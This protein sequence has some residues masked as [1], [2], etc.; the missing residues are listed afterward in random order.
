MPLIPVQPY[1]FKDAV[2]TIAG[3]DYAPAASTIALIPNTT[4]QTITWQGLT[5]D[6]KFSDT[7]TPDTSWTLNITMAQ[8]PDDASLHTYMNTHAGDVETIV[9]QPQR[10][11][12]Q[13]QYT[14]T[15]TIVP[16]QIGGDVNTVQ[17]A[18]ASMPVTGDPVPGAAA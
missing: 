12:G 10:G 13:K 18:Q 8:D 14:V 1:I 5:P 4:Q 6:S 9:I 2:L 3:N 16:V 15:A 17:V 11:S 7:S